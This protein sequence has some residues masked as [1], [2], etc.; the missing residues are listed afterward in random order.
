MSRWGWGSCFARAKVVSPSPP[1][2]VLIAEGFETNGYFRVELP[3]VPNTGFQI[4]DST[5]L[6]NWS[7]IG[8]GSTDANGVLIFEGHDRVWFARAFLSGDLAAA[9]I[10][11]LRAA[12]KSQ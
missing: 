1:T 4:Q 2:T 8:S 5:D 7:N 10:V 6:I 3:S 11:L 12:A 9:V